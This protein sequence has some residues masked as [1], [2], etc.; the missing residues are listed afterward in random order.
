MDDNLDKK[1]LKE[2]VSIKGANQSIIDSFNKK[3]LITP[4]V[5]EMLV[6]FKITDQKCEII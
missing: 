4:K 5:Q 1:Y 3:K 6:K 2:N